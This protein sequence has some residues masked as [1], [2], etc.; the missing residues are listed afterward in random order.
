M[1]DDMVGSV[2]GAIQLLRAMSFHKGADAVRKLEQEAGQLRRDAER[3][4]WLYN[5]DVPNVMVTRILDDGE[6]VA[7]LD[8]AE[9]DEIIDK[10][11]LS[12]PSA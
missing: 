11:R 2:E 9:L 12:A 6:R 5:G 8:G 7:G 4:R 3:Y 1:I 10:A